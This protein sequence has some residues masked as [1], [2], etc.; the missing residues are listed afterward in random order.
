MSKAIVLDTETT[1]L[2]CYNHRIIEIALVDWES[3]E[4]LLNTRVNPGVY[5][6]EEIT[7]ITGIT[8]ADVEGAPDWSDVAQAVAAAI[9]NADA[10]IGYNPFF[11]QGFIDAEMNRLADGDPSKIRIKWPT[12]ICA[13]R[14]WDA[15]E[16]REE[17]NL[18]NAYKRFVNHAGFDGAHGA[19]AD[20]RA[21]RD[22]LMSQIEFF[23][24]HEKSWEE[25]DPQ[26]AKWWGP[27]FHVLLDEGYLTLNFGKNKGKP[28]HEIDDGFWRWVI[29]KDFP[30]HVMALALKM[31]ELIP[32]WSDQDYLRRSLFSWAK[33]SNWRKPR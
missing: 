3:N 11:D 22:V 9:S 10:V 31:R 5:I 20:V 6:P 16:P 24:L 18:Q 26:R 1:G 4:V 7:R 2:D 27:T 30:D 23:K 32:Q 25:F 28:V 15:Y 14:T 12:I 8:D 21:T 33:D 29:D 19:L 17:R 13:K